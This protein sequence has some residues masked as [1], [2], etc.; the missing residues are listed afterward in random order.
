MNDRP[1]YPWKQGE[2]LFAEEL[3][4]AIANSGAYGPFVPMHAN[5]P[6]N[7]MDHGGKGDGVTDDGPAIR[8]LLP[9]GGA[10]Y[11]PKGRYLFNGSFAVIPSNTRIFGDGPN[12]TVFVAGTALT[13]GGLGGPDVGFHYF[14]LSQN[15]ATYGAA[16]PGKP[17]TTPAIQTDR[18]I[19]IENIGFD[20]TNTTT[21]AN[22]MAALARFM[23]ATNVR[24]R[25]IRADNYADMTLR[26][27]GGFAF[28]GCDNVSVESY[29]ARNCIQALDAWAGCTRVKYRH[30]WVEQVSPG[31]N[32]GV[33][34]WQGVGTNTGNANTADDLQVSDSTFWLNGNNG[35]GLFLDSFSSGSISQNVLLDNLRIVARGGNTGTFG[36]VM[37]GRVNRL[38]A[39]GITFEASP[40]ADMHP[41]YL[42]SSA[43]GNAAA[44]G[45]NLLTT[46]NGGTSVNVNY[47]CACG[48]GNYLYIRND[49]GGAVVGNGLSLNGYYPITAYVPSGASNLC[50]TSYTVTVP[51]AAT[52]SGPIAATTRVS[53]YQ[54]APVNMILRDIV[55]DG[56]ASRGLELITAQGHGHVIDGVVVTP[57][58]NGAA[59]PGY[60]TIVLLDTAQSME[61]NIVPAFVGAVT[62]APG[63]G[64]L[65]AGVVGDGVVMWNANGGLAPTRYVQ[66]VGGTA[67]NLNV[68]TAP[69]GDASTLVANTTFATRLLGQNSAP[70]PDADITLTTAQSGQRVVNLTGAITANRV[71]TVPV[72]SGQQRNWLI[73]NGT[74]GPFLIGVKSAVSAT[75]WMP[76]GNYVG[77][78]WSDGAN[79]FITRGLFS[80]LRVGDGVTNA[81]VATPGVAPSNPLTL[82]ASGTGGIQFLTG[83]LGFN[84]A[85]PIA[86]PTISGSRGGNAAVASLLTQLAAYGLITDGTTA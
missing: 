8:A 1:H 49:V 16:P 19:T 67:V 9:L 25:N 10:I 77:E 20:L 24:I 34:N 64:S 40:G 21:T 62:G 76:T 54:G 61:P 11:F 69:V 59:S 50:G 29:Y 39:R 65:A 4:A 52:A 31:G 70:V 26:G 22:S 79:I 43:D 46:T 80:S 56:C 2:E 53:G 68:P 48:I 45:P 72:S 6:A 81:L 57:N 78:F 17:P 38:L 51:T 15:Y 47:A 13:D 18:N 37:R 85:A 58:Y 60:N 35:I 55:I 27:W 63:I 14:F 23:W 83:N 5:T 82:A 74:T 36:I 66:Q 30:L 73:R 84:S 71:V 33:I 75:T 32:G 44:T 12:Q 86:K 42:T 3:N 7:I 41:V 28:L